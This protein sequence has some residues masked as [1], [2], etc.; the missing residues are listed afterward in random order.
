MQIIAQ[1]YDVEITSNQWW[2]IFDNNNVLKPPNQCSGKISSLYNLAV[3][4]TEQ[5]C[6]QYITDNGLVL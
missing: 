3:A 6:Y 2:F 1:P 5:E 4:E